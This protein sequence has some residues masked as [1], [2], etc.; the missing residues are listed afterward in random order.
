MGNG[1]VPP[2]VLAVLSGG[3]F[4]FEMQVLLRSLRQDARFIIF[5]TEWGGEIPDTSKLLSSYP[6]PSYATWEK[7]SR[8]E[9]VR[10]FLVTFRRSI[11]VLRREKVDL[12]LTIGCSHAVPMLAAARLLGK[13]SVFLES[14][15]RVTRMSL[16]GRMVYWF[17]L[18]SVFLVQWPALQQQ[19][20]RS[21]LG[22]IL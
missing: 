10:A 8:W 6:V 21:R 22:T 13:R 15:T 2:V 1:R 4:T 17:G 20:R 19:Y 14:V 9:S 16:S 7:P 3:G 11:E 5:V 18:A 12:V